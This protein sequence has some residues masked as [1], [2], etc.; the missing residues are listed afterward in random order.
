MCVCEN[1][2]AF[3]VVDGWIRA[4]GMMKETMLTSRRRR[5]VCCCCCC[6]C[7][8]RQAREGHRFSIR[9]VSGRQREPPLPPSPPPT[10]TMSLCY[11]L[12]K[13]DEEQETTLPQRKIKFACVPLFFNKHTFDLSLPPP[14]LFLV[15]RCSSFG[16]GALRERTDGRTKDSPENS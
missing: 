8:T 14:S 1:G 6:C 16:V 2:V 4:E 9:L 3:S 11:R 13:S 15:M 10:F 7:C 12:N 5:R